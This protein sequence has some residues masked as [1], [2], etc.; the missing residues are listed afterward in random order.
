MKIQLYI[1]IPSFNNLNLNLTFNN[2]E[3]TTK[4]SKIKNQLGHYC[5]DFE[6]TPQ[7]ENLIKLT[8]TGVMQYINVVDCIIDDINYDIVH[9]MNC[10]A[11]QVKGA[12]QIDGDGIIEIPFTT[13]VCLHW[14]KTFNNFTYEDYPNWTN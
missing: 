13:P 2:K 9:I 6:V 14:A 1:D 8:A 7:K 11:N 10:R 3:I 4:I 12:T 5:W